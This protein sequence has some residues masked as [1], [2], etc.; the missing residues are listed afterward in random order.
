MFALPWQLT[1]QSKYNLVNLLNDSTLAVADVV[2]SAIGF[3]IAT[4][5]VSSWALTFSI[6]GE[7]LF[8]P[9]WNKLVMYNVA[10]QWGLTGWM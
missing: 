3:S 5:L 1:K 6:G 8:G 2:G 4:I 10:D 7:H 9:L